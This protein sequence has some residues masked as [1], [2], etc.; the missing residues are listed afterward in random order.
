M[1]IY[2]Y[3]NSVHSS[4][5]IILIEALTAFCADLHINVNLEMPIGSAPEA[6]KQVKKIETIYKNLENILIRA[7]KA[8]KKYYNQKHKSISF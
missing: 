5:E 4:H 7:K 6:Y 2:I 1:A 8:Q 3:N